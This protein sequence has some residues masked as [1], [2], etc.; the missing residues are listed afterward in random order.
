MAHT[1]EEDENA[2][3]W[4]CNGGQP[5]SVPSYEEL[6]AENKQ[7]KNKLAGAEEKIEILWDVIDQ[8][9]KKI[10]IVLS[11][12][13]LLRSSPGAVAGN[14]EPNMHNAMTD[15]ITAIEAAEKKFDRVVF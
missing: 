8:T 15:A 3:G 4:E 1:V 5:P 9:R 6:L 11:I 7:L 10:Q 12:K 13:F 14:A 2:L